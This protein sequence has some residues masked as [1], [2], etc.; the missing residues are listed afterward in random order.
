MGVGQINIHQIMAPE[1]LFDEAWV[2]GVVFCPLTA[3]D[4]NEPEQNSNQVWVI[5]RKL[6]TIIMGEAFCGIDYTYWI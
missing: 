6:Y 4:F 1:Q 5:M 2:G 3:D